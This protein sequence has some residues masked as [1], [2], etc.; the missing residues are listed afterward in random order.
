MPNS[1][2]LIQAYLFETDLMH[3][4]PLL[5]PIEAATHD[6]INTLGELPPEF[7]E[8]ALYRYPV[9]MLTEDGSCSIVNE[10]APV[11]YDLAAIIGGRSAVNTRKL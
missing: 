7:D 2:K 1:K 5:L 11:P 3:L 6:F 4:L 10:L 8:N 9:P